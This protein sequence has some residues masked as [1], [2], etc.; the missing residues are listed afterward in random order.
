MGVRVPCPFDDAAKI[1]AWKRMAQ[2]LLHSAQFVV[3]LREIVIC[4]F[5]VST[6]SGFASGGIC[7]VA[8]SGLPNPGFNGT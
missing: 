1:T 7:G 3:I 4:I 2:P 5:R 8:V 6:V